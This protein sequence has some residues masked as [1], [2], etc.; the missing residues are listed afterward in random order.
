MAVSFHLN[1]MLRLRNSASPRVDQR[2]TPVAF[3]IFVKIA[4]LGRD[5]KKHE[6][7]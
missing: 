4:L 7:T 2:G 5:D 6:R 3:A 1:D